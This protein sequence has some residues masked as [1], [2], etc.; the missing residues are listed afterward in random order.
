MRAERSAGGVV[1]AVLPK[2]DPTVAHEID[3][4]SGYS[5]VLKLGREG[6]TGRRGL[7]LGPPDQAALAHGG[8]VL[9]CGTDDQQP[10]APR[11]ADAGMGPAWAASRPR[12]SSTSAATLF[13][14][15]GGTAARP[16]RRLSGTGPQRSEPRGTIHSVGWPV[17]ALMRS[18]SSS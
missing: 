8:A 12:Y 5:D 9:V 16:R 18:K 3:A 17:T 13:I 14:H 15:V 6:F 10:A 1:D 11:V 2:I 7:G 4:P